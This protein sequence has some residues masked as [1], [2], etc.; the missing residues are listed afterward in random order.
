[1]D[2]SSPRPN[3]CVTIEIPISQYSVFT[4][5]AAGRCEARARGVDS[6]RR[7]GVLDLRHTRAL[8]AAPA[9]A[10]VIAVVVELNAREGAILLP[11][12]VPR[13]FAPAAARSARPIAPRRRRPR[14][15]S[16]SAGRPR[17]RGP[18]GPRR[19]LVAGSCET[20]WVVRRRVRRGRKV[21]G[22]RVAVRVRTS[23]STPV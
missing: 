16:R 14:R 8:R 21:G 5:H 12:E 15:A 6:I 18:G 17:I 10:R 9:A 7:G 2:A 1:M 13:E 23:F 22:A 11:V 20:G 4:L 19:R 3:S